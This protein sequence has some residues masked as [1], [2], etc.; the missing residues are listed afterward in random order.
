M[1][2]RNINIPM[3]KYHKYELRWQG[4]EL[5]VFELPISTL[6][7]RKDQFEPPLHNMEILNPFELPV[8][9][10]R[11]RKDQ[12]EPPLHNMEILNPFKKNHGRKHIAMQYLTAL[13]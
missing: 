8:S 9:P 1:D 7:Y 3:E 6:R 4:W 12:L 13:R 10:L 2:Y 5:N 11:Y